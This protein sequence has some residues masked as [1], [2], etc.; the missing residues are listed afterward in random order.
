MLDTFFML[1][2]ALTLF[3]ASLFT[4]LNTKKHTAATTI[5]WLQQDRGM[6]ETETDELKQMGVVVEGVGT[7]C[8]KDTELTTPAA[9]AKSDTMSTVSGT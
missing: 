4:S 7:V 2:C 3:S 8:V 6:G 1:V 5:K 9:A